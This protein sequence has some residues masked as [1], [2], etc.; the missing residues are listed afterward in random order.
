MLGGLDAEVNRLGG[1]DVIRAREALPLVDSRNLARCPTGH[2]VLTTAG[3]LPATWCVHTVGPNFHHKINIE[4]GQRY[5]ASC[6]R[7]SFKLCA[8]KRVQTVAL[9]IVSG[10]QYLA[11]QPKELVMDALCAGVVNNA[12]SGLTEVYLVARDKPDLLPL[13]EACERA[14]AAHPAEGSS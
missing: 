6:Y 11:K 2:A 14:F 10:G 9:A 4:D 7:Q 3:L 13:Q 8:S 12:Y 5:L 1:P